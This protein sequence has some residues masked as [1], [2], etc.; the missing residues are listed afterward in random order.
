MIPEVGANNSSSFFFMFRYGS[1]V[2]TAEYTVLYSGVVC[3]C[4]L[5]GDRASQDEQHL[6]TYGASFKESIL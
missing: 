6:A 4:R 3:H 2:I 1:T 5:D